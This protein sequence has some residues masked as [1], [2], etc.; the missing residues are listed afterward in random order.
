MH[1]RADD[2][3]WK[4]DNRDFSDLVLILKFEN[5][6]II[7]LKASK[8]DAI[9]INNPFLNFPSLLIYFLLW[10]KFIPKYLIFPFFSMN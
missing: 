5:G 7:R 10:I 9:K 6:A 3:I 2:I 1:I 8:V 4:L